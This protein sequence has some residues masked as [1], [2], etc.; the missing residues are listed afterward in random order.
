M[1]A[2]AKYRAKHKG[3]PFNLTSEFLEKVCAPGICAYCEVPVV[4]A[5]P[6]GRTGTGK[7]SNSGELDRVDPALG[8]VKGNVVLA[9]NACNIRKGDL[10][11]DQ[12]RWLADRIDAAIKTR[13]IR[14]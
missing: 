1:L 6:K 12:L 5:I 4:Y 9:C 14:R 11:P 2:S 3:L 8:Y 10:L 7:L 13:V